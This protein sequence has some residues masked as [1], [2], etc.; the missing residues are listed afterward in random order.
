MNVLPGPGEADFDVF[1]MVYRI[2][3]VRS[4]Q[5]SPDY[6]ILTEIG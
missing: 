1:N 5:T 6:R 3:L 2:E 4:P